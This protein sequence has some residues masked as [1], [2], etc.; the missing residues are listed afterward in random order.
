MFGFLNQW[1]S[2]P[3]RENIFKI[4]V[5][6]MIIA[7]P[8]IQILFA[9]SN[10]PVFFLK[11]QLSFSGEIIK[12]HFSVMTDQDLLVYLIA[13]LADYGYLLI[14]GTL[15]FTGALKIARKYEKESLWR[16]TGNM[17]AILGVIA[18]IC[19]SLENFCILL[20]LTNPIGFPDNIAVIHSCFALVK[21]ICL[22]LALSWIIFS[23]F[24]KLMLNRSKQKFK[25][26]VILDE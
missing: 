23:C 16:K 21:W 3:K 5:I 22:F 12:S 19:D 20:M 7:F 11:S 14:Y 24:A 6:A 8:L 25:D 26:L 4:A 10:Y 2:E 18:P 13:Q 9:I 17:S 1:P 15:I